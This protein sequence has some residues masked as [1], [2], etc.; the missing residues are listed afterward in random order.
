MML[1]DI[2]KD[3]SGPVYTQFLQTLW[4]LSS[5]CS[6]TVQPSL[7]CS[8]RLRRF[9]KDMEVHLAS[10]RR[11]NVW[12]GTQ[13]MDGEADVYTFLCKETTLECVLRYSSSLFEWLQPDL[14]EDLA[15]YRNDGSTILET[16]T[17]E[18]EGLLKISL[19]EYE[20]LQPL[21]ASGLLVPRKGTR[22]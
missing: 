14:P 10:V 15:L 20:R 21:V 16:V 8:D 1:V 3:L 5:T 6:F 7:G 9:L 18:Q 12:P 13:L 2:G 19:V 11:S 22:S 17:H 4:S